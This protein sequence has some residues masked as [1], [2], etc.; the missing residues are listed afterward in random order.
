LPLT[1][2]LCV[3]PRMTTNKSEVRSWPSQVARAG[4]RRSLMALTARKRVEREEDWEPVCCDKGV[5]SSFYKVGRGH[6]CAT[7]NGH[8]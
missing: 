1:T 4:Y 7:K 3:V 6:E 5:Q 2:L 8:P